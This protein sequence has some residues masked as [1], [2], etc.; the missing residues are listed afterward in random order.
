VRTPATRAATRGRDKTIEA[1]AHRQK[2]N[3]YKVKAR[4]VADLPIGAPCPS[5]RR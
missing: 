4:L 2:Y 5:H 1:L 3:Y